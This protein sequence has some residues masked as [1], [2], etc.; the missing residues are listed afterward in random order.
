MSEPG[1]QQLI[2][3]APLLHADDTVRRAAGLIRASDGSSV[4]VLQNGSIAGMVG[5]DAIAA[6]LASSGDPD[7]A[8]EERIGP[9]VQSSPVFLNS[10]VTLK[11]SA[12]VFASAGTDV[13]PVI[14]EFGSYHGV[15]YRRDV[16]AA[17]TNN[18]R[19]STTAGMATPLGVYLTTGSHRAGAGSLGLFLS[20]ASLMIMVVLA[21]LIVT[22]LQH[23]FWKLTGIPVNIYA[24]SPP[25]MVA[26]SNYDLVTYISMGLQVLVLL[27]LLRLSPMSGYHAAE[28]MTVHAI[29]SGETLDPGHVRSMPRVHPRCGTNL[30]AIA[31]VV[32]VIAT[33][34][35]SQFAI[36]LGLIVII[37][38]WRALG[39]WMQYFFT[40]KNPSEKQLANGVAAGNELLEKYRDAPNLHSQG[41]ERIWNMGFL[42]SALGMM[43][44]AILGAL[45]KQ[46]AHIA[47][48]SNLGF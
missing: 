33:R 9:L 19:P 25:L 23:A 2:K 13:L 1:I 32:L 11:E 38:G 26:Y 7:S 44:V 12:G 43:S 4:V 22:G 37:I 20:G 34:M 16:V 15:L 41:F 42:Q 30:L 3:A 21:A 27:L 24:Q 29:E 48:L 31:G 17:L 46:Y 28:H 5:E 45:L 40:T 47:W 14:G 39:G 18:L 8:R 36:L 35:G 10:A 6:F